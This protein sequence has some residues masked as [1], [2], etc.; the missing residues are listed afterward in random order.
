MPGL[1][2]R[3]VDCS[4]VTLKRPDENPIVLVLGR[5]SEE[6]EPVATVACGG[7][8]RPREVRRGQDFECEGL[9][10]KVVDIAPRQMIIVEKQAGKKHTIGLTAARD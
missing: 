2:E 3:E 7:E 5:A 10:Y 9:T 4:E 8:L 6:E 1:G